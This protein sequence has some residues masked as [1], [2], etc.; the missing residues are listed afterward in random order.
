MALVIQ[1][2]V[3]VWCHTWKWCLVSLDTV[4]LKSIEYFSQVLIKKGL[5]TCYDMAF[6]ADTP[7]SN[8]NHKKNYVPI[9]NI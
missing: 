5:M 4:S 6:I 9:N 2:V 8:I 1:Q 7:F 3:C